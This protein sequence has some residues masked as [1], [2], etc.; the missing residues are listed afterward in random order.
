M[1]YPFSFQIL[2]RSFPLAKNSTPF[3]FRRLRTPCEKPPGVGGTATPAYSALRGE[4]TALI[5]SLNK[6]TRFAS[7]DKVKKAIAERA[8]QYFGEP[9][10]FAMTKNYLQVAVEIAQEAGKILI[11]EL[12]RPLDITY[13]G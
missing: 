10:V 3:I 12:S 8:D 5:Q 2:A 13:K 6:Q 9:L 4:R 7:G 11:E 1:N